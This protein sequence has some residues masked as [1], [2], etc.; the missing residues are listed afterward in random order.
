[1]GYMLDL[2]ALMEFESSPDIK[3]ALLNNWLINIRGIIGK[4]I[5]ADLM[6]EWNNRWLED[7]KRRR[8]GDL[9]DKF[10]RKTI[11]PNVLHFI[12]MKEDIE[13]AFD[14]K[15]RSK[16]HTSP[17]LRDETKILLRMYQDDELHKFRSGR[18]MGHAAVNR[19]DRG[20]HRLE[21]GKMAEYLRRSAEY[22]EILRDMEKIRNGDSGVTQHV[23]LDRDIIIPSPH[24]SDSPTPSSHRTPSPSLSQASASPSVRSAYSS[25]SAAARRA[26]DCVEQ[27]DDVDHSDEPLVSGSDIAFALDPDTGKMVDDWYD[28]ADFEALLERLCGPEEEVEEDSDDEPES[29]DPDTE[30]EGEGEGED[31]VEDDRED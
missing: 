10:Y 25:A 16:A 3:D 12:K 17:H 19:F 21:G 8:G 2:Y 18:S 13:T 9:D 22:A 29:D 31:L 11:A 24:N 4:F 1:M 7:M 6:Q 20:F 26:A 15:R 28:P 5:E 14:L 30:S 23:N 27:W